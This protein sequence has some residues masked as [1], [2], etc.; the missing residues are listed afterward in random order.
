MTAQE[1]FKTNFKNV[2][3]N[4][5]MASVE[6]ETAPDFGEVTDEMESIIDKVFEFNPKIAETSR[7]GHAYDE[8]DYGFFT[9]A[10]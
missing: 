5:N 4:E 3:F 6:M 8:G 1:F 10:F 2:D 9:F 7:L